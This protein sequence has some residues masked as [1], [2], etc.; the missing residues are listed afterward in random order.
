LSGWRFH[1]AGKGACAFVGECAGSDIANTPHDVQ[2]VQRPA[3]LFDG[4]F[5]QRSPSVSQN[6]AVFLSKT[7]NSFYFKKL[8]QLAMIKAGWERFS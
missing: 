7:M 6:R 2:H 3:T 4:N 8:F 5:F 1:F